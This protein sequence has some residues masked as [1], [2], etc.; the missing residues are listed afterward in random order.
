MRKYSLVL[1]IGLFVLGCAKSKMGSSVT[2]TSVSQGRRAE[3]L[4]LGHNSK[5]HDSGKYAPWLSVKLFKSGINM[6]YTADLND[7]NA[8]NLKKYDGLIIYANHDSLSPSQESAVKAFVEGGKGLIPLHSASGCFK[9]SS[10]YIKTIGGQF[11]SHKVGSFKNT[12]LKP[13]H[14]VMQGITDF[15]T[16]DETY[17]HKNLNPDKTVL[18]ERVEGNVHE[19]YT[20]VRNEGKGRVFYTAY[21]HEDSTWTNRGFLDL[22]RNGVMW[23][24]G[25][26]VKAEIAALK[27]PDVDI[28]QSDTIS[29]Y[30]KRHVV[31]KMQESLSPSESNKLTQIPA[32]FEIQL[33]AAEPDITNPIAMAW[34][35]RGRLW[36]VESVDYPNTFKETDGAANDRIKICEDTNGDGKADKFTVFADKLNI[37]TSMVFSNGGIIVSMAP[38]FVFMKDTNGDDVADVRDVIMTGWGKNDT[39]AGPSNL[40]Y[41]FDNKIWGVLGYSG[42]N[43]TIDGKKMNFSQGVYHF[44]PDGKEFAYLGSSSNNTWG[45]GMTEDNNV[46]LSTANNTHSAYYSIPGQYM[47]RTIGDDQPALL[48]VQKIDGHYDAHSL[49]PNLRQVDVV[50]G[51]TSAA[52]HRFYT[53]RNFP[54]EYWNRIAFVSE[55]TIRL[56]HKAILEPDGAGF[57]EKDGWNFMASSDEWFGPVQAETGPDGAVWIADWYNFIIQHNVFVPAQSPAEFIMPS[58]EQ[59]PGPGNAFSSPMRDLNHGRIYRVVYKNARKTPPMK[60]SKDDLPGLIAALENDNMFWRMTAQRLLVESKK[61]SVVPDLYKIID[62]PK[63]DEIGL[64]SPAVH[65]L[66]TLHGLGVLDGSNAEA[67]QVANRAL[68]HPAAGVRKAAASVLPKNEQSFEMLQKGMKDANLNTRLSVFVALITLPASEKVGEA[69]YRAALDE[70]N[71]KDPWLSKALLAAAISHEKGFLAAS[72]QQSGKSAFAGQ[73]TKALAKEVYPLGRRNTLQYPPDVSGKEITI[74]ASVTKAKDKAL[75]GFIAGQGGKDGGYALYIQDGKLI[76][77]VKQHG[78]MSQATTTEPLPEKFDVVASLTKTGDIIIAID[79]KETAKGKAHMLFATPLSNSVRTGEDMEGEDKIGSY[80]GKFG[81]AG[82]FQKASLELNRPSEENAA[83]MARE[84]TT[85]ASNTKSSNATVIELKV[86]KEIMQFDKKQLTVK[87][88]QKVVI[89]LENPDGMQHNL[90]IIKP[91]TLQKVG[92]AADE[93]LRDPKAA[94]KQYVPKVPEVLFATRL[95]NSGETVTLEFTVPNE[96]G[97]YTY[98]CTFPGHWRGM[99]GILRVVK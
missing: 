68:T 4:F 20:W 55:P 45:L 81:F 44:K 28:Y 91:G 79:G 41:G 88:G 15:E 9:N 17:V 40:Q 49:T 32:D 38:D 59:P 19:P 7:I 62:N 26:K 39:H 98:V 99:N 46:F 92:Q 60:L 76:M 1:L 22:V 84:K 35:E 48:S 18:G 67:L 37:P 65:A 86:E 61:L 30:T 25:D 97:D 58:K 63:V 90:V 29:H 42:F 2:K 10:W 6:T 75:Q 8:D 85:T 73:V 27:L 23:A 54:K 66:W 50:G 64:N 56:V 71:A 69:V 47:Q 94:E 14:P 12:I 21:G 52:G 11:A 5:H 13:D 33:F 93:M 83:A 34:D 87:A 51:F 72:E 77:A 82:N 57:K 78:M 80:E 3:V 16:W 24:V 95:V 31:P 43:G 89:N 36:V 96:P 53:A 70:Q 74:K